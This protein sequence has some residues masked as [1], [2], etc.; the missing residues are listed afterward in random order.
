MGI[1]T[2]ATSYEYYEITDSYLKSNTPSTSVNI[3][4]DGYSAKY[5]HYLCI[6]TDAEGNVINYILDIM[7]LYNNG[8][9]VDVANLFTSS[10]STTTAGERVF[11]L[12]NVANTVANRLFETT[13]ANISFY[14]SLDGETPITSIT[15][16]GD[17]Q[18]YFA[19]CFVQENAGAE[20]TQIYLLIENNIAGGTA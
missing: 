4:I 3:S 11:N 9:E 20:R 12:S 8:G 13:M 10:I 1:I 15:L 18:Y 16:Q 7:F 5:V 17:E 2:G 14:D 19:T 6:V